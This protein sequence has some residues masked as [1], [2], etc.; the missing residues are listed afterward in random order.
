MVSK[1]FPSSFFKQLWICSFLPRHFDI[2]S[3]VW[4]IYHTSPEG[5]ISWKKSCSMGYRSSSYWNKFK[6]E[7]LKM[8]NLSINRFFTMPKIR[9]TH[10]TPKILAHNLSNVQPIF[11][12]QNPTV[13]CAKEVLEYTLDQKLCCY[14]WCK[15]VAVRNMVKT[16]TVSKVH[17]LDICTLH[18]LKPLLHTD[19]RILNF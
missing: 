5:G 7:Y 16:S 2:L 15:N 11:N 17:K 1:F 10:F 8:Q 6:L 12:F 4:I 9:V 19:L 3:H 14:N 18:I 13:P